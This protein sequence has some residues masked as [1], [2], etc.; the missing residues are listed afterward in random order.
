MSNLRR[1]HMLLASSVLLSGC[2][3]TRMLEA[4]S[5][6]D[7]Q[8]IALYDVASGPTTCP[9]TYADYIWNKKTKKWE[10]TP[11]GAKFRVPGDFHE[12]ALPI[13][14]LKDK[15]NGENMYLAAIPAT[16]A[17]NAQ[18]TARNRLAAILMKH[19][20]DVFTVELGRLVAREAMVNTFGSI[21]TSGLSTVSSIV[22]PETLKSV[23]AGGASFTNATRTH[24]NAEVY[25]NVLSTAV[26]KAIQNK[27]D[28]QRTAIVQHFG[29]KADAYTVD[30][31]IMEVNGY[32]Q[33]CSFYRGLG[34]VI[35]A[36]TRPSNTE[37]EKLLRAE[38]ALAQRQLR[39]STLERR[40]E[41]LPKT[42]TPEERQKLEA[43]IT[44]ASN[45]YESALNDVAAVGKE[46]EPAAPPDDPT[47]NSAADEAANSSANAVTNATGDAGD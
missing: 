17:K 36:V 33:T 27:R 44:D 30:Q 35:Q 29:D 18:A 22:S 4:Q 12:G 5:R 13:R 37:S 23:L 40:L 45:K 9:T 21:L 42:A 28:E 2:T 3:L 31:M 11:A 46:P 47:T 20:D 41:K 6:V 26:A 7:P 34:L 16:P 1:A 38:A 15:A 24:V 10:L 32:H 25:R 39:L 43:A 8:T 19:S 14:C